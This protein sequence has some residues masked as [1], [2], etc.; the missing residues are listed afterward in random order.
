[1]RDAMAIRLKRSRQRGQSLVEFVIVAPVLLFFCFGLLQYA[2][3][4]QAKATLDS[5][6][7][8][9]ARDGAVNHAELAPMQRALARGLAP[10]YAHEASAKGAENALARARQ[11]VLAHARIAIVN[12]T[13]AQLDDFGQA[14]YDPQTRTTVVEI[15]NDLLRYRRTQIGRASGTDIQDANLLKIRVHYCYDMVVPFVNRAVYYAVNAIGAVSRDGLSPTE[16]VDSN[17]DPYGAPATPDFMC[18]RKLEDGRTT[19]RW[20]IALESEVVVRMQSAY[21]GAVGQV[22]DR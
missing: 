12:P 16:P 2:L 7:L 13:R 22:M 18:R 19:G 14:R 20:P 1:M 10:L 4:Y 5:A 11:D 17:Q 8:E 9:A 6:A 21:R 15:P 3:M